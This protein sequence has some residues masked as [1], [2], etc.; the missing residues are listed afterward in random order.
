MA[1]IISLGVNQTPEK[2]NCN[3]KRRRFIA[4]CN[5]FMAEKNVRR[6]YWDVWVFFRV[7]K[8]VIRS[9]LKDYNAM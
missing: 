7:Y 4:P 5:V 1:L 6:R 2:Q 8:S 9:D 3:N